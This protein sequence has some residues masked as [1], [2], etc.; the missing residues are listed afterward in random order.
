MKNATLIAYASKG[1]VTEIYASII[2]DILKEKYNFLVNAV[3]I[4]SNSLDISNY[5]N[6]I[7]GS[8]IRM[9]K[10]Y[11]EVRIFLEDTNFSNKRVAIFLA[12]LE[13][14]EDA[15]KKYVKPIMEKHPELK[16]ITTEVFGGR[17]KILAKTVA[18]IREP[19]KVKKWAEELGKK[20]ID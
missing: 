7:V 4:K 15:I 9:F 18:D 13:P 16:P 2:A 12:S 14:K 5:D 19:D 3:K 6:I 8:G 17:M 11:K 10:M 20:L 1:G